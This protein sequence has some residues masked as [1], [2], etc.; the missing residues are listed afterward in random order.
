MQSIAVVTGASSG[1]GKAIYEYLKGQHQYHQVLGLSRHGP[2][3]HTDF[4]DTGVTQTAIS[5]AKEVGTVRLLVNAAGVWS[6]D[7]GRY[8]FEVNFWAA[9]ALIQ[10]FLHD[11]RQSRGCVINIASTSGHGAEADNPMY[12]ASKAAL[13]SLTKSYALRFAPSVR[14]VSISPGF[15]RTGM[16]PEPIPDDLLQTIPM[17]Y[18]AYPSDLIPTVDAIIKSQYMTGCDIV[19]DGGRSCR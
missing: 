4:S 5:K 9:D 1:I 13:I 14:F 17:G 16:F 18:E 8:A 11:L 10:A 2:D 6:E 3:I 19:V 7:S 15:V 12:G